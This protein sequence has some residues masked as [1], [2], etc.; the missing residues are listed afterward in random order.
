MVPVHRG[1]K[2]VVGAGLRRSLASVVLVLGLGAAGCGSSSTPNPTNHATR[3]APGT[4]PREPGAGKPAVTIG[5]KNFTEAFILGQ[6]YAQALR[7]KGFT[8][9]LHSNIGPSEVMDRRLAS[10]AI[11]GY[12]EYTGT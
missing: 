3:V 6:L 9:N 12:P 1:P 4:A 8:V 5:T 7:A 2:L 11:D 10:A